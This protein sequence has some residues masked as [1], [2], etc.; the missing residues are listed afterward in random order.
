MKKLN[1]VLISMTILPF[2]TIPILGV[3][4]FKRFI[5]G[6]LFM[7]LY[8]IAEGRFAEKRKWW[9]F[10]F[11]IKP[12]VLGELPLII[13]PFFI[14]SIW[15]LKYTFGKFNLYLLINLIVDSFFT[16][17]VLDW[18]KKIGYVSLVRLSKFQLS[19]VFLIKTFILYG[20][21]LFYEKLFKKQT[22]F[23]KH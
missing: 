8:L 17:F 9:W 11:R 2:L 20:T 3:K 18:L 16:Y 21:Q 19:L 14:G 12:N 5:P 1:L 6:A 4:T 13:G 22:S 23:P 15:I 10:P 7:S